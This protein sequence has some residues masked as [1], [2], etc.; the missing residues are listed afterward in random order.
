[1]AA[2]YASARVAVVPL[3]FGAG[4]KNK[5]IEAMAFGTPLVTTEIGAQ[6]IAKLDEIIPVTSDAQK[7]SEYVN[8]LLKNDI[9]WKTVSKNGVSFVETKYSFNAMTN[10]LNSA[11]FDS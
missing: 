1:M 9:E 10:T 5:V 8:A 4:V 2:H 6:G 11:F 3:R 7:F